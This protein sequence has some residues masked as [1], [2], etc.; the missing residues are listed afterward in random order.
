MK[1]FKKTIIAK[2]LIDSGNLVSN[3]ISREFAD[4]TGFQYEPERKK[5]GTAAK[6]GSVS[7]VG[8]LIQPLHLHIENISTPV[9]LRPYVVE[10]LSHP[11]NVG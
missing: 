2:M 8:R 1:V 10:E 4:L 5:V 7:I 9:F 3:L 6:G 11:I